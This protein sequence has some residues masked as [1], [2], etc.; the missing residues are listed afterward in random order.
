[1]N[2]IFIY[3]FFEIVVSC[4]LDEYLNVIVNG[5]LSP[6]Q[7]SKMSILLI[8]SLV[9]FAVE[10]D[11]AIDGIKRKSSLRHKISSEASK[12]TSD[13]PQKVSDMLPYGYMHCCPCLFHD[14]SKSRS[15]FQ[16]F[17][18]AC[19]GFQLCPAHPCAWLRLY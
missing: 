17:H 13:I 2:S 4:W 18:P 7:L 6:I 9:I 8:A 19:Y 14:C 15:R 11:C 12:G 3:V 1:M 10:W 5:L 16:L